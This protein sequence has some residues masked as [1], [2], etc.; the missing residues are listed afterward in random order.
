VQAHP[1]DLIFREDCFFKPTNLL[2]V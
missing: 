2:E 1:R